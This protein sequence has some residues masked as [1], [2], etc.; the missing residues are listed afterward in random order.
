MAEIQYEE[1]QQNQPIYQTE[2]KPLFV[3]L[4]LAT[5]LVS[6]ERAAEYVLLGIVG[7][8]IIITFFFFTS[9]GDNLSVP[10]PTPYQEGNLL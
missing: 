5:G 2:Q 4:V 7:L 9:S 6:S 8:G 10:P 3:R 1:G